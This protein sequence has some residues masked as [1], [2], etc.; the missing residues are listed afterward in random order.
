VLCSSK[1]EW[2]QFEEI[3]EAFWND[4]QSASLRPN[5]QLRNPEAP[6]SEVSQGK[7][8]LLASGISG[9]TPSG[10]GS[11][12]VTGA[13]THDRLRKADFST[14]RQDDLIALEQISLR[15]FDQ[16]SLNASRRRR[17]AHAKGSV[18]LRRT[19]RSSISRGG[20]LI[21]LRRRNRRPQ[22]PRLM[23]LLDISG[24]MCPYCLFLFRFVYAL[25]K[26]FPR[27]DAFLFSTELVEVTQILQTRCLRDA[28]Q[29]L[30]ELSAGWSGGTRIGG[31]LRALNQLHRRRL[32][33]SDTLFMVLSDGW[34]TGEPMELAEELSAIKRR[35]RRIIWLNPLLGLPE[36]QPL[37]RGMSAALPYVDVFAPAHN[38]DSL[39]QLET[40]LW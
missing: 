37:T 16:I 10:E 35:V 17:V 4:T 15:L 28:L 26:H 13:S 32:R 1:D 11:Q 14:L 23:I 38:L 27:V 20:E 34:D 29:G 8:S 3:F 21:E 2:D 36:Y 5:R 25:K 31:S 24:S 7:A 30:S 22:P 9:E 12:S 39:M 19:I 33:S 6:T 40:H 18:D